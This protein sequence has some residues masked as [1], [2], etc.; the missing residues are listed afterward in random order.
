M[1][2]SEHIINHYEGDDSDD[3]NQKDHFQTLK[4]YTS[5][6][7]VDL[8]QCDDNDLTQIGHTNYIIG[9]RNTGK[10]VLFNYLYSLIIDQIDEFFVLTT[11][12]EN[13]QSLTTDSHIFSNDTLIAVQLQSLVKYFRSTRQKNRIL[14]IDVPECEKLSNSAEFK[15]LI[16]NGR[17]LHVT[18][19]IISSYPDNLKPV[20]RANLDRIFIMK[21]DNPSTIQKLYM[22][23]G[24]CV[25][26][27]TTFKDLLKR[28][29][30]VPYQCLMI[31]NRQP[32]CFTTKFIDVEHLCKKTQE[33]DF[34]QYKMSV[35]E[36]SHDELNEM[37]TE[38]K[39]LK[40]LASKLLD[41]LDSY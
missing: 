36:I 2:N 10:T 24:G 25:K 33:I 5:P 18:I 11:S 8:H 14:V 28:A 15:E 37:K 4:S 7:E 17:H 16:I 12:P 1:N 40:S 41:Q 22:Q 27:L 32:Q 34:S 29:T 13:Y 38:L 30:S 35:I 19:F 31:N 23:F 9:R 26:T 39:I 6:Q 20:I 21:D 3:T